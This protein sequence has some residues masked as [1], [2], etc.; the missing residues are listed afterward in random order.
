[1]ISQEPGKDTVRRRKFKTKQNT[2]RQIYAPAAPLLGSLQRQ[3]SRH[4]KA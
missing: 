1:M 2:A 3:E 4:P